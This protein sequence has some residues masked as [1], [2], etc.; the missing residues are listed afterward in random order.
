MI[1]AKT[2]SLHDEKTVTNNFF[3]LKHVVLTLQNLFHLSKMEALL[4]LREP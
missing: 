1:Q 4:T 2:P 3:K